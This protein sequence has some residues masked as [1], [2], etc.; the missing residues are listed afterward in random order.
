M[1]IPHLNSELG[2]SG[3]LAQ[4]V[5]RFWIGDTY[6]RLI[7]FR[8]ALL[9]PYSKRL[10][11][12]NSESKLTTPTQIVLSFHMS[13][14]GWCGVVVGA[15][16]GQDAGEDTR[17]A[18]DLRCGRDARDLARDL[19]R[20]LARHLAKDL[21]PRGTY[22]SPRGSDRHVSQCPAPGSPLS[23]I[24]ELTFNYLQGSAFTSLVSKI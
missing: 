14:S 2:V 1:Q 4:A 12:A 7:Y 11:R 5:S 18:Q 19:A 13:P 6:V 22:G 21:C 24:C 23:C 9:S 3:L 10:L 15:R 17:H 16:H 8:R 20:H